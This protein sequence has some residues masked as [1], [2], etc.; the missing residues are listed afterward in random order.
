[1]AVSVE[2]KTVTTVTIVMDGE[3]AYRLRL[4]LDPNA[5]F[6]HL[7]SEPSLLDLLRQ[8]NEVVPAE[9]EE[10]HGKY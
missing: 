6:I 7:S 10:Y 4:F 5:I 9:I 8:L 3:T 1:M 2:K